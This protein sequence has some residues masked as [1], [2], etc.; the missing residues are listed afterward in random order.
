ME[1]KAKFLNVDIEINSNTHL[2]PLLQATHRDLFPLAEN[3]PIGSLRLEAKRPPEP[4]TLNGTLDHI[5]QILIKLKGNEQE[6]WNGSHFKD[7]NIGL[8]SGTRHSDEFVIS[9]HALRQIAALGASITI[10]LYEL[11]KSLPSESL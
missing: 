2:A 11:D 8:M 4:T 5:C 10:T 3:F 9:S 1:I 7:F 6:L